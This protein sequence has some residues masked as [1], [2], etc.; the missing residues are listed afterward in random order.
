MFCCFSGNNYQ[1]CA[2]LS[3]EL[4]EKKEEKKTNIK[5]DKEDWINKASAI[6]S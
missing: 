6:V 1:I 3:A 2:Y 5:A 4:F